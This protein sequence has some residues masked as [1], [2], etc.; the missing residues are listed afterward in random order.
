VLFRSADVAGVIPIIIPDLAERLKID[1]MLDRIDGLLVTGSL[2]NVHPSKYNVEPEDKHMP[3]DEL[4]D[5]TSLPL[6]LRALERGV[7]MLAICRGIQ[8]L[9]V[10]LGGSITADFQKVRGLEKHSYPWEGTQDERF[11][12]AHEIVVKDG[13]HL[14]EI[15]K[16]QLAAEAVR[17]NSLH[18]QALDKLGK[19]VIVEAVAPDGTVEAVS[20]KDAPGF[21][22]GVQWHPEYWA[23]TDPASKAI[24]EAFGEAARQYLGA[25]SDTAIAAE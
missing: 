14:A 17:V 2:S 18:T 8:E 16:P 23:H 4:R 12:L 20:V 11:A 1:A 24:F 25:K 7:P 3:F 5:A 22:I 21:A 6:I 19:N 13:S 15:L 10:A 9:N